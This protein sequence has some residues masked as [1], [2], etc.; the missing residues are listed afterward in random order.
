[1][2]FDDLVPDEAATKP[3][4]AVGKAIS[5]DALVDDEDKFDRPLAAGLAGAAKGATFGLSSQ[6]LTKSGL[7]S[8]ETLAGLEKYNPTASTVG[9][10]AGVVG[11][12][13]LAPEVGLVGLI[14]KGGMAAERGAAAIAARALPEATTLGSKVL[15]GVATKGL[16]GAVEGAFYGA[17]QSLHEEALG[18][19]TLNAE[20][21]LG[22]IGI[23][24]MLGG[25]VG[26]LF[27]AVSPLIK[28]LSK[29]PVAAA[30]DIATALKNK[31]PGAPVT[32]LDDIA[33]KVQKGA[34]DGLE[35]GVLPQKSILEASNAIIP[36][37]QFPVHKVQ[38]ESMSDPNIR[39]IYKAVKESNTAEGKILRDY[40][41]LQK[42]EGVKM[43][44]D[45]IKKLS[46][47]Q[48]TPDPYK[49]G[50]QI[51]EALSG[52][53]QAAKVADKEVFETIKRVSP[54][55][56]VNSAELLESLQKTFPDSDFGNIMQLKDGGELAMKPWKSSLPISKEAYTAVRE[57]VEGLDGHSMTLE[58]LRN[59][60]NSIGDKMTFDL[61]PR[62]K[63]ELSSIKK[64]LMD[65]LEGTL[66]K[67]ES[68]L[69]VRDAFKR[70]AINESKREML[71]KVIGGKLD[72]KQGILRQFKPEQLGDKIFNNSATIQAVRE[73]IP[74][75]VFDRL[76][77]NYLLEQVAKFT[78]QGK[79]SSQR[80]ATWTKN[81]ATELK[82][83]FGDKPGVVDRLNAIADKLRILP[84]SAPL[85]PSG[86]AKA[87]NLGQALDKISSLSAQGGRLLKDPL[88]IPGK[89]LENLGERMVEKSNL[90]QLEAVLASGAAAEAK[91]QKMGIVERMINNANKNIDTLSSRLFDTGKEVGKGVKKAVVPVTVPQMLKDVDKIKNDVTEKTGSPDQYVDTVSKATEG[92]HDVT[93]QIASGM[94][95]SMATAAEFIK[96]K[97]PNTNPVSP[98]SPPRVPSTAELFKF[99]RYYDVVENPFIVM[100][101][102]K[103]GTLTH[104]SMEAMD[105]VYP[106]LLAELRIAT[107][108]KLS[109][110]KDGGVNLPFKTKMMLS[111]FLGKDLVPSITQESLQANQMTFGQESQQADAKEMAMAQKSSQPGQSP[112]T[113][114]QRSESFT[115]SV[116]DRRNA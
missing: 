65:L 15:Q 24:A 18:D 11:S 82:M 46:P 72:D 74:V 32:A 63:A 71:E 33:A 21:V 13:F 73:A 6:A 19:P 75:D 1:M 102:V 2:N 47:E 4:P 68:A 91:A 95:V 70:Y 14:G 66:Q 43:L 22:N 94:Q 80:F 106:R 48:L 61:A 34:A 114:A 30:D 25:G 36:D 89:F 110:I 16:G 38:L 37:S 41:S 76:A 53:Y 97:L 67:E 54:N 78:D 26:G 84:D 12:V 60:R 7:V 100:N 10:V 31:E 86:T 20:K 8:K 3:A 104:E 45:T 79:F 29:E 115:R 101:Q 59:V 40:E 77:G 9:E 92:F 116:I 107:F 111:A 52:I 55:L 44:D 49:A 90:R 103:D 109:G 69:P 58:G 28:S 51:G 88:S 5:F 98:L 99:F 62:P 64:N 17:G 42:T 112:L 50:E 93:P 81:N 56:R 108:D 87:L 57:V 113:I 39:D 105:A 96:A 85:N 27:G 23:A 83:A 35:P